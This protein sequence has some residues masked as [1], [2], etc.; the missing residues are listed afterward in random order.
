M[1]RLILMRH[2][3]SDWSHG[4]TDADRPL[5]GRGRRSAKAMG[6]WLRDMGATPDEVLCSSAAR[7]RETLEGL[8]VQ[9]PTSYQKALYLADA[10]TLLAT[11]RKA[12]GAT[13][14][15]LGHNPGIG[16][17]AH[18]LLATAPD[19]PRWDD[20]PTCSTLIADFDI[21]DWSELQLGSGQAQ[22]FA[23]GRDVTD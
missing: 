18:T 16:D 13:V 14:L 10:E 11:L 21:K 15:I 12:D 2:A 5:N 20:F 4:V 1:K 8:G 6:L 9:A 3:K 19:H 22:G 7:T 17:L 23:V